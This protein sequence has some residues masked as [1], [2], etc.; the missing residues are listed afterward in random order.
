MRT[1][2]PLPEA[3]V[4]GCAAG[5]RLPSGAGPCVHCGHPCPLCPDED[6]REVRSFAL[7]D[8]EHDVLLRGLSALDL[9]L[10]L[11]VLAEQPPSSPEGKALRATIESARKEMQ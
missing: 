5:R 11:G 3:Y 1:P 6:T 7:T 2:E 8:A 4:R 10:K 9:L